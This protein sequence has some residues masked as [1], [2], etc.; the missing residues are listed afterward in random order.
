MEK[1]K[2]ATVLE[3]REKTVFEEERDWVGVSAR[4]ELKVG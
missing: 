3:I 4:M 2:A 1:R